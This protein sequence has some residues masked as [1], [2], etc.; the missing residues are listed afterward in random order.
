MNRCYISFSLNTGWIGRIG[1][2]GWIVTGWG[3]IA[4]S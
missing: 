1:W 3:R 2:R 4:A